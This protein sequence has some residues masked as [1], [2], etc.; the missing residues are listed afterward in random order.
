MSETAQ[1]EAKLAIAKLVDEYEALRPL[2]E[3]KENQ[4]PDDMARYRELN[5]QIAAANTA[6]K[7]AY[8]PGP[9]ADEDAAATPETIAA[10]TH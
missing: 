4:D 1:L 8:P 6:Y 3:D 7:E 9:P 10:E 2:V 5:D